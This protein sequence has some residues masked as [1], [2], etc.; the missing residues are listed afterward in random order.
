MGG[1]NW[2][3][4]RRLKFRQVILKKEQKC[5]GLV[6]FVFDCSGFLLLMSA[7]PISRSGCTYISCYALALRGQNQGGRVLVIRRR[8]AMRFPLGSK[9][10]IMCRYVR[11]ILHQ[12]LIIL[13]FCCHTILKGT[14]GPPPLTRYEETE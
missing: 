10:G 3:K 6:C 8:V 7:S 2:L 4:Y 1:G 12:G 14:T 13:K 11:K 9:S 5:E